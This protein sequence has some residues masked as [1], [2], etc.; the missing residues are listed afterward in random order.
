VRRGPII[1]S[2]SQTWNKITEYDMLHLHLHGVHVSVIQSRALDHHQIKQSNVN[3]NVNGKGKGNV[4]PRYI[5]R[6]NVTP[7]LTIKPEPDQ[8]KKKK[9][10]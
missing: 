4:H 7:Y 5:Y 9:K 10:K 6:V 2:Q 8:K 1:D 3:V